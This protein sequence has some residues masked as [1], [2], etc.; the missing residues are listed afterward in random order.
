MM[1]ITCV[2]P[3]RTKT[4]IDP[5]FMAPNRQDKNICPTKNSTDRKCIRKKVVQFHNKSI[6][7]N[8]NI[9]YTWN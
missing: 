3:N 4:W 5:K 1:Y 7:L 9:L 8:L 2:D 6:L